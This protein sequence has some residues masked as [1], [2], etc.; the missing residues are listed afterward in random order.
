MINQEDGSKLFTDMMETIQRIR[1]RNNKK[2]LLQWGGT[3]VGTRRRRLISTINPL[4][5][6]IFV[7][8]LP[9]SYYFDKSNRTFMRFQVGSL[10]YT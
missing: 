6:L 1:I 5:S 7:L 10:S 3:K 8:F 2:W 9:Y 4:D